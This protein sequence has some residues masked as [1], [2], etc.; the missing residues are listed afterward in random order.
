MEEE[1]QNVWFRSSLSILDA[2]QKSRILNVAT[3]GEL[4]TDAS[5]SGE[6]SDADEGA[7]G[8]SRASGA[9]DDEVE[10]GGGS[11]KSAGGWGLE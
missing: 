10:D 7:P 1:E 4:S 2:Y 5:S 6:D 11:G 3:E 9:R 8:G